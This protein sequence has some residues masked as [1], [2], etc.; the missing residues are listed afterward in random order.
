MR[1]GGS[2]LTSFRARVAIVVGWSD[3]VMSGYFR[4][5]PDR[6]CI[7]IRG[8]FTLS[9]S[10][11]QQGCAFVSVSVSVYVFEACDTRILKLE[12]PKSTL[13]APRT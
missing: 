10:K 5:A 7:C 11:M 9:L 12:Q 6:V 8:M 4:P 2:V 13:I 1:E 3:R